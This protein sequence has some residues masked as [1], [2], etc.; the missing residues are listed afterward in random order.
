M[1]WGSSNCG[2]RGWLK[3]KVLV[4]G[5]SSSGKLVWCVYYSWVREWHCVI[6]SGYQISR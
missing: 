3:W 2:K 5:S 6:K 1:F 4:V